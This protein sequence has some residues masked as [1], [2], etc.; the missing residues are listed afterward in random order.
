VLKVAAGTASDVEQLGRILG[1]GALEAK[2][3]KY[4]HAAFPEVRDSAM[5]RRFAALFKLPGR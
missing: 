2:L 3:C 5:F 1:E 4:E